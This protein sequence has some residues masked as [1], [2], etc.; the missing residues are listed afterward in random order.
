MT[1]YLC[2]NCGAVLNDGVN[3][4][5]NCGVLATHDGG[6]VTINLP[7]GTTVLKV[8][9]IPK[10]RAAQGVTDGEV[11]IGNNLSALYTDILKMVAKCEFISVQ[12]M[13]Y[14]FPLGYVKCCK[15]MEWLESNKYVER[16]HGTNLYKSLV[17][18]ED[19]NN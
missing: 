2:E 4:C 13:R 11:T 5:H 18:P 8:N 17:K 6:E 12:I 3:Y 10:V 7:Q 1:I 9:F 19:I 14:M 15:V 16:V